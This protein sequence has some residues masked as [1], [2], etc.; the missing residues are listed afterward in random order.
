[1]SH[2]PHSHK[3]CMVC[4]DLKPLTDFYIRLS[5]A[6]DRSGTCKIC[7]CAAT[8][9]KRL[10]NVEQA[11]ANERRWKSNPGPKRLPRPA[12][13]KMEFTKVPFT[14]TKF[15]KEQVRYA[16]HVNDSILEVALDLGITVEEAN[17]LGAGCEIQVEH[18][19]FYNSSPIPSP[20][21]IRKQCEFFREH[22]PTWTKRRFAENERNGYADVHRIPSGE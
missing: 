17:H 6:D 9:A 14:S 20:E 5:M 21:E 22:S 13:Q 10:Q 12:Q 19:S 16:F 3:N 11:R 18:A 8:R 4:G 2:S 7:T 15:T 1:M